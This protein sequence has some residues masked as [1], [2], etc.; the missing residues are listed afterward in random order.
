MPENP[1]APRYF[2][3]DADSDY[4]P[5]VFAFVRPDPNEPDNLV[6]GNTRYDPNRSRHTRVIY[7]DKRNECLIVTSH[8]MTGKVGT[9]ILN[10]GIGVIRK[11]HPRVQYLAVQIDSINLKYE[12]NQL[13]FLE[14]HGLTRDVSRDTETTITYVCDLYRRAERK[15]RRSSKPGPQSSE[16]KAETHPVNIPILEPEEMQSLRERLK[17]QDEK[18]ATL[19]NGGTA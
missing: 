8:S 19:R 10:E 9:Q 16:P 18:L 3:M 17:V 5:A 12:A 2:D 14:K 13:P 7:D 11:D 1:Y 15:D 4:I 6:A